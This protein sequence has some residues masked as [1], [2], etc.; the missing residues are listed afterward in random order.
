MPCAM[1]DPSTPPRPVREWQL[2]LN[3]AALGAAVRCVLVLVGFGISALL[4]RILGEVR[5]GG[6][7]LAL[8]AAG[9]LG[10][11]GMV[12]TNSGLQR[13]LPVALER[14]GVAAVRRT[15][16]S[17]L[18]VAGGGLATVFLLG[19]L[20]WEPL[21]VVR[22]GALE[23]ARMQGLVLL[24]AVAQ[25]GEELVSVYFRSTGRVR[26][27]VVLLNLP[28][29]SV[30]LA[31]LATVLLLGKEMGLYEAVR[32]RLLLSV[33]VAL[34]GLALVTAFLRR[35]GAGSPPAGDAA[36]GHGVRRVAGESLP[37]LGHALAAAL[38]G[39]IDL[40]FL[41]GLA[42]GGEVGVYG[43]VLQVAGL[44]TMLLSVVNLVLPPVLARMH[45]QD[46]LAEMEALLR[47]IAT[48]AGL[49][50][51]AVWLVF[52]V[53]GSSLLGAVFGAG[54]ERGHVPLLILAGGQA[55]NV[56]AG[57]PGW[58]LQMTGHQAFLMRVTLLCLAAKALFTWWAVGE[59][60]MMGAALATGV[61]IV[62]QN[63]AMVI[64]ARR[65]VGVRTYAYPA[66]LRAFSAS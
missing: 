44:L 50:S 2:V 41:R 65:L 51:V 3:G 9:I 35:R 23:L 60:G 21:V 10:L 64:A 27:G 28:R 62:A 20:A 32:L 30:F 12:G 19:H 16:G 4:S 36:T 22:L 6:Y 31:L 24:L 55:F 17:A 61:V 46:R 42:D 58:L 8:N 1:L 45:E 26:L 53:V 40:W 33:S 5:L 52:A 47:R 43:A 63:L 56:L 37:M 49:G 18:L 38:L 11:L 15:W 25:A 7:F 48:L 57:S 39:A 13:L 29:Q 54:F 59:A 66:F 34:L 14:G